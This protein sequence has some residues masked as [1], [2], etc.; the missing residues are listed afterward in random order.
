M[1]SSTG[2]TTRFADGDGYND[3]LELL[4]GTDPNDPNSHP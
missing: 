4:R 1:S 3:Y 2:E